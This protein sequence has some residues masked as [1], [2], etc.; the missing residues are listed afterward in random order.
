MELQILDC[1]YTLV[2][3]K[4]IIRLFCKDAQGETVC[5]FY[6]KF[7]PYFYLHGDESKYQEI[8]KEIK[9]KYPNLKVE[10]IEKTLPIGYQP[11]VK[12]LKIT[13]N[14]PSITPEIR[15]FVK[16]FGTP[17]EADVLF[18]YRFMA[19][20][21]LK[22]MGWINVEG[23]LT[24]TNT[25]KCK[26]FVADSIKPIEMLKNAPLKIMSLDIECLPE[27]IRLPIPE[28]DKIIVISLAFSP[29][30]KEK[31]HLVIVAKPVKTNGNII[32][33]K[34][35]KE[36]LEKF[37][38]I[39]DDYDADV[40]CGHNINGFDL[41]FLIKRLEALNM[42]RDLGRSEKS[43][44][45]RKLQHSY[46]PNICGRVVVDSFEIFKRDPWVKFKRYDLSTISK[47]L[48]GEEKIDLGSDHI[49]TVR[50][51]WNGEGIYKFIDYAKKDAE[52]ALRLVVERRLLDKF[53]E[54]AKSCGLLLQD[55]LGGQSQRHEFRL[56]KEFNKRN[57]IVPC[58]PGDFSDADREQHGLKGALVLE[59][60]TGLH[61]WVICLDFTSMYP[62]LIKAFNICTTTYLTNGEN[63]DH[64]VSPYGTKFVKSNVLKG[65]IPIVV[66]DLL[67]TR[68]NVRKQLK[69]E[70]DPENKRILQ[71]KQLA[72]KDLSNSV[73]PETD[74]VVKDSSG[75]IIITEIG[76]LFG[77]LNKSN[78]V[79]K[80]TNDIEVI[81]LSGWQ[82]LSVDNDRSC[83]KPL[84]AISRHRNNDNLIK[85][86]TRMGEV[87]ITKNHSVIEMLG[88]RSNRIR[89]AKF[90]GLNVK[91]GK[92]VTHNTVI[93]QINNIDIDMNGEK[94]LN[95]IEF[96]L[97][98]P[99]EEIKDLCM[100][101]PRNL[102]LNKNNWL[103]NRIKLFKHLKEVG[104]SDS[105]KIQIDLGIDRRIL[106]RTEGNGIE[107]I[108]ITTVGNCG[109]VP[110]YDITTEA[111]EYLSF[112]E[113]FS[114]AKETNNFYLIP[115]KYLRDIKIPLRI[116]NKS[117]I[118]VYDGKKGG[119]R[120]INTVIPITK[121][122]AEFFGW[123]VSEGNS[124]KNERGKSPYY[125]I[126]IVN[127]DKFVL[128]RLVELAKRI[129]NYDA[130]IHNNA[131]HFN[132]KM[133]YLLFGYLAGHHSYEKKIPD[134]II[135]S[136]REIRDAFLTAY[137][138]GDGDKDGNRLST[139]SKILASQLSFLL[140]EH[141]CILHNGKDSNIFR[142]S[143]RKFVRGEKIVS[144]DLFGQIPVEI[145]E[146]EPT[147]YVYD[148]SVKDT[149]K[150]VTAQGLVLH[151]SL[152]GYTGY[153]RS[154]LY[155][156]DIANTITAFGRD[157]ITK[158][159]K[160]IE[161]NF[162]VKVI[163]ADT[164]S[165]FLKSD[166]KSLEEAEDFGGRISA[167][168]SERLY[169]LDLKFEKVYK[170]FLI[171]TKKRYAGWTFEREGDKWSDRMEMKGIETVRRDW[172]SLASET[173][174]NVLNII[175]KEKDINKASK[176]VRSMVDDLA[177]GKI[178]LEKL[179][180]IKGITKAIDSYN[181]VQP[182]IE[183]AKKLAQRDKSRSLV[184][185][186][187]EY[188]IIKGNQLLSK[189]AEDP[190]FVK[191]KGLEIDPEYYIYNQLLPP[192]E[193]IFEV[194]GI[195]S[196]ELLEGVKQ[197]SLLDM[198]N[199]QKKQLSP[200]EIVLK[201]FE[202]VTCKNCG[203]EFRRPTLNGNCP[204]CSGQLYFVSSGSIG[205]T[206]DLSKN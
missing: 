6:D 79:K 92:D 112:Y 191:E 163:Y 10:I 85:I 110:V 62:S 9:N 4:P 17:Y 5:V 67:S 61:E 161:E 75:K 73:H 58:K 127:Y 49:K 23:K 100:F 64:F 68:A 201:N 82:T 190:K 164:D 89:N 90:Y 157:T 76:K 42:S 159:K 102:N 192:L 29:A 20:F 104:I 28:K 133:F 108:G 99:D 178:P 121:E 30:Y 182:H 194:C 35:E 59:P 33:C 38:E 52:L 44:M 123:Y 193:R 50:E 74:I 134:F 46:M 145:K 136:S 137:T 78:N 206:V 93:A 96:L 45:S 60:E 69:L 119:R 117:K 151:N 168:V 116:L 87:K 187:L 174:L 203:W 48:L 32:A 95:L 54:V 98:L 115:I 36:M 25:V 97:S 149:E 156:M 81:E 66:E 80:I 70:K 16:R 167:F 31:D 140:K 155:V 27:E 152:Y 7:F 109:L 103:E 39:L 169:G 162:P 13:G 195:S 170:T 125:Y 130:K 147:N 144:G 47:Q 154:R 198:L 199:G 120:K 113:V 106:R 175:L 160:L 143:K 84:Y 34:D 55:C 21:D 71:A 126:Q 179:A 18:R 135:N 94:Y 177:K 2:N 205:K 173:M 172:C 132:L 19:D 153:A 37:K 128:E 139:N 15:E 43:S 118:S 166:V 158:T 181:G 188:V 202:M 138:K 3:S 196:S 186:R 183:L 24:K 146:V 142:I 57:F 131:I 197:K 114:Y 148:L 88:E 12:V 26:A 86:R 65:I 176:Y 40:I 72:L 189:R 101:I 56:L 200:E 53:L 1:D 8:I 129:F 105:A 124:Y 165:V 185:E 204:K 150:F 83:F 63:I 41:P 51:M 141:N 111:E 14:D 22:G 184:G 91:K 180:I 107:R 171:E 77:R 122:L 11:P